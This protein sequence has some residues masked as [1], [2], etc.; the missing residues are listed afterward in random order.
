MIQSKTKRKKNQK[1]TKKTTHPI[2]EMN[3]KIKVIKKENKKRKAV[4]RTQRWRL[5]IKLQ[6]DNTDK[7][8]TA[9]EESPYNSSSKYDREKKEQSSVLQLVSQPNKSRECKDVVL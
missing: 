3:E 8:S 7:Q 9:P 6:K 5:R 2:K 1:Q 4:I